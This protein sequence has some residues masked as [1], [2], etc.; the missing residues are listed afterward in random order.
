[1][2]VLHCLNQYLPQHHGGTEVYVHTLAQMQ[3]RNGVEVAVVCPHITHYSPG[4]WQPF[5][6]VDNVTVYH[7]RE[8]TNPTN[9][10]VITGNNPPVGLTEFVSVIQKFQPT[11]IHFHELNRS[12]GLGIHHVKAARNFGVKVFLTIHLSFYTCNTNTLIKNG[13]RC[14]GEIKQYDCTACTLQTQFALNAPLAKLASAIAIAGM[15]CGV[16]HILPFG[17]ARTYFHLP[18]YINR[19]RRELQMLTAEV[20]K[21]IVLADWYKKILENNGVPSEKIE[22]IPQ[23]L[24]LIDAPLVHVENIKQKS[25]P[26]QLVF[27]GRVQPQKALHL[28]LEVL[29]YFTASEFTLD[30]YAKEEHTPY[31]EQC[32]AAASKLGFVNWR[33]FLPRNQVLQTLQ[34]YDIL[35]LPS[36]FSEMSPLVIQEAFA[37]GLPVLASNVYGNAE[38]IQDAENGL[39]FDFNSKESLQQKLLMLV[40]QPSLI[41]VLKSNGKM[42]LSFYEVAKKYETLYQ[43]NCINSIGCA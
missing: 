40:Q 16:P 27:L 24:P 14:T 9:G 2:R 12:V 43:Y 6:L 17:K 20:D 35:V 21:F 13:S 26:I 22:N 39:L 30:V 7:Y 36:A 31:Y 10:E 4:K 32:K 34:R 8:D 5:T 29:K 42:P 19:I 37:A 38:Q 33:G 15:R 25:L 23:A 41:N 3:Q 18:A 1:M 28:L 11:V